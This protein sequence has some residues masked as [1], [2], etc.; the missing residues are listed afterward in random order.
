MNDVAI[1]VEHLGKQYRLGGQLAGY[2]TA[3][4]SLMNALAGSTR[5]LHGEH[6]AQ[7]TI[8]AIDD[9]SFELK[10]GEAVGIIGRNGA[11]KSTLLKIL[12]RI[13]RPTSG[14]V[15][16]FGRVGSLLEVGTGFH[17]ELTG[18]ENIFLNGAILGMRHREI[19]RKFDEIVDFSGVEQ[20]LDTAVKF[21]SSGMYVRLA[22]AVAAHLEP[23]ILLVDEVLSVGDIEFQKKC[24]RKMSDISTEQG[25]TVLLVSH[26]MPMIQRLAAKC[27]LLDRGRV[28]ETGSPEEVITRY[29]TTDQASSTEWLS[30]DH[31]GSMKSAPYFYLRRFALVD[32]HGTA[33]PRTL[34]PA[35]PLYV[36]IEGDVGRTDSRLNIGFNLLDAV[37]NPLMMSYQTDQPEDLWPDLA[38]GKLKLRARLDLGLLNEGEYK[39]EFISGL[40]TIQMFYAQGDSEIALSFEIPANYRVSPYWIKRRDTILSPL[41]KWESIA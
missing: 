17:G 22:F 4:E 30:A 1:R 39:I 37:G 8:W 31:D 27:I 11:G 9:M 24:L 28:L 18:R 12:S 6:R 23:D 38:V 14:R 35:N 5:W 3:R 36:L 34:N 16:L 20:F 32:E 7:P 29:L 19:A 41:L 2:K 13:T 33:L 21:Y 10:H 25:R 15:E 40:H 26:Q